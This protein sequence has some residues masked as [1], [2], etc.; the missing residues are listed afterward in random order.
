[1]VQAVQGLSKSR[2]GS[3]KGSKRSNVCNISEHGLTSSNSDSS[4]GATAMR[5]E[6]RVIEGWEQ[7]RQN[8][9]FDRFIHFSIVIS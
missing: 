5:E 7:P 6:G 8:P 4:A 9:T 2:Q 1:M 3:K